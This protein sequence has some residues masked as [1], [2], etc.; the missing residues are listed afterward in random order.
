MAVEGAF[1]SVQVRELADRVTGVR[2]R[3]VGM[4]IPSALGLRFRRG[5]LVLDADPSGP[6]LWWDSPDVPMEPAEPPVWAHHLE[7][8]TVTDVTQRGMDRVVLIRVAGAASYGTDEVLLVFEA[9]GRNANLVLVRPADDRILTCMRRVDRERS[10]YRTVVPGARYVPPPPS[11]VPP[12]DWLEDDSVMRVAASPSPAARDLYTVLE[13]VGPVTAGALL[14]QA[15]DAGGDLVGALGDLREAVLG[16]RPEPCMGPEGPLPARMGPGEP[17]EDPLA[18]PQKPAGGPVREERRERLERLLSERRDRLLRRRDNLLEALSGLPRGE[19]LRHWAD[20]LMA[21]LHSVGRGAGSV[22]VSD[23]EGGEVEIPL[24]SS[25]TASENAA[26]YYRKA[27]SAARE[28]THV[29][30]ALEGAERELARLRELLGRIP[31]MDDD[32]L[33]GALR[34][35]EPE[36]RRGGEG[37]EPREV[38][39]GDGWR[40]FV[41]R[42]A[43]DNERVTFGLGRRGDLWLHVRGL[44]GPHV[45]VKREGRGDPPPAGVVRKA[46]ALAA[47]GRS[48]VVAVDCTEVQYVRR[49][50]GGRPGEVVYSREKTLFIDTS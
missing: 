17:I 19:T 3:E 9:A 22:T 28:R 23:W 2:C 43:R 30:K 25:R 33:G 37:R 15:A 48:G 27:G 44:P 26:R 41:G 49:M 29:Q 21:N 13:G 4:P 47:A 50:K 38:R 8:A 34:E 40:C 31:D 10:R 20:L 35:W 14:R 6:S 11:G 24:R 12:A 18:P 46:A 32:E 5:T 45:L 16:R 36:R 42:N 7:G 1:M 39:L